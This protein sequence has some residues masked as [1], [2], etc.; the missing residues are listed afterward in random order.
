MALLLSSGMRWPGSATVL[1]CPEDLTGSLLYEIV[2]VKALDRSSPSQW[3]IDREVLW[4]GRA[5]EAP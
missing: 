3:P 4:R 1:Q 2:Y 5:G